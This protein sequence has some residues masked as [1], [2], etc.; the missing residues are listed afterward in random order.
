M[1]LTAR[2]RQ[3]LAQVHPALAALVEDVAKSV[4]LMVVEGARSLDRQRELFALG[5]SRTMNS[6]HLPKS[7]T[8]LQ[9]P[10]SHAV[11]LAP[12]VDLD[13]D[14]DIELSWNAKD[15]RPIA[16]AMKAAAQR[17]GVPITWGGDWAS[18]RDMPHFELDRRAYP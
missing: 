8:G 4:P 17:E 14:G 3:R 5:K 13:G 16:A 6:R 15:F 2:D 12:L 9:A 7:A 1:S 18:F 10:V 11:D